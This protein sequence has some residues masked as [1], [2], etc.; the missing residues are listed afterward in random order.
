MYLFQIDPDVAKLMNEE[1]LSRYLPGYGD[2][3]FANN[4][5]GMVDIP[6]NV[7]EWKEKLIDCL[8]QTMKLPAAIKER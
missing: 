2:R 8:R 5:K 3:L 6:E 4:W 1:K 7:E